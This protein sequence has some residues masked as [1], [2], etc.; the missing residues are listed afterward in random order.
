MS[1]YEL[2][3]FHENLHDV[4]VTFYNP[5]KTWL[6][7][8]KKITTTKCRLKNKS[9]LVVPC[10]SLYDFFRFANGI[11]CSKQTTNIQLTPPVTIAFCYR[12]IRLH[13]LLWAVFKSNDSIFCLQVFV[14]LLS[15]SGKRIGRAGIIFIIRLFRY[16]YASDIVLYITVTEGVFLGLAYS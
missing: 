10:L 9:L 16:S 4:Y 3:N 7:F 2:P 11:Q 1:K 13:V 5:L 15:A 6:S 12:V 8:R 14:Q